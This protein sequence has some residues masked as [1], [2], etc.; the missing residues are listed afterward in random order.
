MF[1]SHEKYIIRIHISHCLK[2]RSFYQTARD[3]VYLFNY[4]CKLYSCVT[5]GKLVF[6]MTILQI[7]VILNFQTSTEN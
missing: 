4:A 1:V 6:V 3:S 7:I 5:L 2:K